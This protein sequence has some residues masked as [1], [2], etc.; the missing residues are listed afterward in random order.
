MQKTVY[1]WMGSPERWVDIGCFRTMM[2]R[3]ERREEESMDYDRRVMGLVS[4]QELHG[5]RFKHKVETSWKRLT[6][7]NGNEIMTTT[8]ACSRIQVCKELRMYWYRAE[9]EYRFD[10][11]WK[12]RGSNFKGIGSSKGIGN[13][14]R[15]GTIDTIR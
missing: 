5:E 10:R 1:S 3:W 13:A 8:Q 7:K 11:N 14:K 4:E 15:G 6:R 12:Y 9:K 2:D